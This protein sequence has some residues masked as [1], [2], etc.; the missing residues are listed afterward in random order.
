ME[1]QR[2]IKTILLSL[3]IGFLVLELIEH[4][5]FP[6]F[7]FLKERKRRSVCGISGMLG[8]VGEVKQW[9]NNEGKIFVHGELWKADSKFPLLPGDKVVI[10][11]LDGLTVRV[12]PLEENGK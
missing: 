9:Q 3:L 12:I 8:K 4:A 5:I 7:W 10:Q 1:N 6:L 11:K 2:M